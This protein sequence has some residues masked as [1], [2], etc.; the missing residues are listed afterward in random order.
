LDQ[1]QEAIL[2]LTSRALRFAADHPY[3]A[4]GIF[5]AA[6]GSAVTYKVLKFQGFRAKVSTV[7]TP[8]VYQL[9]IPEADL[10][11]MLGDP[12]FELRWD[13]PDIAMIV[14]AEKKEPLKQLPDIQQDPK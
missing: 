9:N 3:A 2:L 1:N 10:R 11:R 4:T 5:G 6:V 13:L 14:T 7:V 8:K 12:E